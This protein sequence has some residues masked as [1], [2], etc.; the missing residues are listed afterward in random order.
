MDKYLSPY[1]LPDD[2]VRMMKT[3]LDNM[4]IEGAIL[5]DLP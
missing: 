5:T 2:Y 3:T 4:Q 1:P